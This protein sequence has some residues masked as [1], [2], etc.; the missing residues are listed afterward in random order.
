MIVRNKNPILSKARQ[1]L[2]NRPLALALAVLLVFGSVGVVHA[3]GSANSTRQVSSPLAYKHQLRSQVDTDTGAPRSGRDPLDQVQSSLAAAASQPVGIGQQVAKP[4]ANVTG[5]HRQTPASSVLPDT[6][7]TGV[8]ASGC[9]AGYGQP[10]A[11]CIPA[12]PANNQAVTCAYLRKLLPETTAK[13]I[14]VNGTDTLKLDT[15]KNKLACGS[16]D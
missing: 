6:K 2:L 12:H 8:L 15:N 10:G 7:N 14:Q 16:G 5:T 13:G 9:L 3:I 11:Q 1:L 4:A